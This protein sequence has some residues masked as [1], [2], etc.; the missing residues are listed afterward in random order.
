MKSL[1]SIAT[2][3]FNAYYRNEWSKDGEPNIKS[4][5]IDEAYKV[6]DLVTQKSYP[7]GHFMGA[8]S[9]EIEALSNFT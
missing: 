1:D 7:K 6:Q 9:T 2:V 4:L 3:F 8:G 5:S